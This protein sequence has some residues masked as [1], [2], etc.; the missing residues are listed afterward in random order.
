MGDFVVELVGVEGD[1][2]AF[3]EEIAG[4]ADGLVENGTF[5]GDFGE[6]KETFAV[7]AGTKSVGNVFA[8]VIPL[9]FSG[10]RV[11]LGYEASPPVL[12]IS[13]D[14]EPGFAGESDSGVDFRYLQVLE[15]LE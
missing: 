2:G 1:Y 14:V 7:P 6:G 8:T 5:A 3:R 9:F 15:D 13:G 10:R 12:R 4:F 11:E